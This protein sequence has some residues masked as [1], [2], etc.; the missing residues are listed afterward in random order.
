MLIQVYRE[1]GNSLETL[2]KRIRSGFSGEWGGVYIGK[3]WEGF[4]THNRCGTKG[5]ENLKFGKHETRTDAVRLLGFEPGWRGKAW[6][7]TRG[8]WQG[9]RP[10][11]QDR[12]PAMQEG[13]PATLLAGLRRPTKEVGGDGFEPPKAKASRFT[14][15][16]IWPLW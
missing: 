2:A 14:V 16:P 9:G 4:S 13:R 11:L 12:R 1:R 10:A 7:G 5:F 8:P 3:G 15:C 6:G